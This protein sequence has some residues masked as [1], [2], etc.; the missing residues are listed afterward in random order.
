MGRVQLNFDELSLKRS[1]R[2]FLDFQR[3]FEG[4]VDYSLPKL[5]LYEAIALT[6]IITA[7][8][9]CVPFHPLP[10]ES[11]APHGLYTQHVTPEDVMQ[12]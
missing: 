3:I 1:M 9:M 5:L 4:K 6:D 11:Q 7:T 8:R 2:V 12:R 10:L